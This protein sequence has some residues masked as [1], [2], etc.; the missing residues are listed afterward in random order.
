MAEPCLPPCSPLSPTL[1]PEQGP[2][3]TLAPQ[4]AGRPKAPLLGDLLPTPQEPHSHPYSKPC[5]S[6]HGLRKKQHPGGSQ[7]SSVLVPFQVLHKLCSLSAIPALPHPAHA[8]SSSKPGGAG[9]FP[10]GSPPRQAESSPRTQPAR[11]LTHILCC[12][13]RATD[14][15]A[16]APLNDFLN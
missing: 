8:H 1:L 12:A 4:A 5:L 9:N 16:G 15:G 10:C 3:H 11:V 7:N 14:T 2:P 6:P 13:S